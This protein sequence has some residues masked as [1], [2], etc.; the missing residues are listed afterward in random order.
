MFFWSAERDAQQ[1]NSDIKSF[2]DDQLNS[3]LIKHDKTA[4]KKP[5]TKKNLYE[6]SIF[7]SR[8][9]VKITP[10]FINQEVNPEAR[11]IIKQTLEISDYP[12]LTDIQLDEFFQKMK[13]KPLSEQYFF[14]FVSPDAVEIDF[15]S[16][17]IY[18]QPTISQAVRFLGLNVLLSYKTNE[19][20]SS[21]KNR[22]MVSSFTMKQTFLDI[23]FG[24][25]ATKIA[26]VIGLAT[27]NDI[28]QNGL[29]HT[30]VMSIAF[31]GFDLPKSADGYPAPR[32]IDFIYHDF[33]HAWTCSQIPENIQR[34]IIQTALLINKFVP[35]VSFSSSYPH[36]LVEKLVDM[37]HTSYVKKFLGD[38]PMY[39]YEELFWISLA[40]SVD[41]VKNK[42]P[43][44]FKKETLQE[45]A[46]SLMIQINQNP[47][48]WNKNHIS[49]KDLEAVCKKMKKIEPP[50]PAILNL[51][52]QSYQ[53][54]KSAKQG[55]FK[56]KLNNS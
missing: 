41:A 19:D 42:M 1:T 12:Q 4:E 55:A 56:L 20:D 25:N 43:T 9:E 17:S 22:Y 45:I 2:I 46:D 53:K 44:V 49:L 18:P 16:Y 52:M 3:I 40:E 21:L 15:D 26:P 50:L 27:V 34:A 47:Q 5:T 38:F 13:E 31:P 48:E 29:T 51:F 10:L 35:E 24:Q 23:K 11:A 8:S 54:A 36:L 7:D 37:E 33:Y 14:S 30:R 6:L 39:S 28:I 32:D